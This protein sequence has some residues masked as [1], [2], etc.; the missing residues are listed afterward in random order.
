MLEVHSHF[1]FGR[2]CHGVEELLRAAV[3]R[4]WP[5]LSLC[6]DRG[7]YGMVEL[8]RAARRLREEERPIRPVLG[9]RLP[10][11]GGALVLAEGRDGLAELCRLATLDHLGAGWESGPPSGWAARDIPLMEPPDPESGEEG[12]AEPPAGLDPATET[13]L[14]VLL[15]ACRELRSCHLVLPGAALPHV[16]P[17]GRPLFLPAGDRASVGLD[18]GRGRV[19][20]NRLWAEARRLGLPVVPHGVTDYLDAADAPLHQRIRALHENT[21]RQRILLSG[22]WNLRG[23]LPSYQ[24]FIQPFAAL[25]AA[26]R[27]LEDLWERCPL[28][29]ET[30]KLHLPRPDGD[31]DH[32]ARLAAL[33]RAAL[34]RLYPAPGPWRRRGPGGRPGSVGLSTP[35]DA[36]ARLG[37]ELA[38]IGRLGFA[39]YFL[40]V[41]EITEFV[42]RE[43]LPMIGRGS[44]ANSLVAYC[45]GFTEVDPLR[46][47][48]SFE[49]F[50]N[51]WRSTPPDIDLDFSWADRDRVL[52]FVLERFGADRAALL[53]TTVTLG[54]RGALR[55]LAK[56]EGLGGRELEELTRHFPRGVHDW[57]SE[58]RDHPA[59]YGLRPELEPLRGLLP[60]VR[61]LVGLPR[62]LGIHVGGV[63]VTPGPLTDWLPL[64]RA[65]RGVTVTQLDMHPVE[66]L[67]LL[68]I[69]LLAQRGLGVYADLARGDRAAGR[70]APPV[71][72][73]ELE[74][75]PATAA[76][77]RHGRTMGCF[78]I[79]S[80]GMQA[81][82][83]KLRCDSFE[84]LVAASSIIRP[85]VSESGMMQAYVERHRRVAGLPPGA[86]WPFAFPHPRLRDLLEDTYGVM[87]YQEDVMHVVSGLA[88][89]SLAEGDLLRRAMSGKGTDPVALATLEDRF[90]AGCAAGGVPSA[91]AREVW[92]QIASFAGYAFCKAHSA[93]FAVLSYRL[94]WYKAHQP[95]HFLAAVLSNQGGFFSSAAYVQEARRLG[96]AVAG[97]CLVHGGDRYTGEAGRLRVGWQ[98]IRSLARATRRAILLERAERSFASLADL[99]RRSGA[100]AAELEQLIHAGACDALAGPGDPRE[101]RPALLARLRLE[102][103]VAG[104]R[105]AGSR[106]GQASLFAAIDEA[107]PAT[108]RWSWIELWLREREALGFGISRHPLELF[109][110]G[111]LPARCVTAGELSGQ[112]GRRVSMIGWKFAHKT[113]RT[114]REKQRMAFLSLEDRTGTWEAVLFPECWERHA[115]LTRGQGPFLLEGRVAQEAGEP[116][117]EVEAMRP[118]GRLSELAAREAGAA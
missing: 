10:R 88:G 62:H 104:A 13:P 20:A 37:R 42:R 36:E 64:Q 41:R 26:R 92:R 43:G 84:D 86:A 102:E 49:R 23:G 29:V 83:R 116:M 50:L 24:E 45:L 101:R 73:Y 110:F 51:P 54:P 1:S 21:S 59:R 97:P 17:A 15:E 112:V 87:V 109:D 65:G 38:V 78:Y 56:V 117:L 69:D 9:L 98:Q 48:L 8:E 28:G 55:E 18:P 82:L 34:P 99:R 57:E 71:T 3:G 53:C 61:R 31:G 79:E 85:G 5:A 89:M 67:G 19:A 30:G 118:A 22:R 6:D 46:H 47:R 74:R 4:G 2:G 33:C 70:E 113:I 95:A 77:I 80:P 27:R 105:A 100:S 103:G 11:L 40:V 14:A 114:R 7:L 32:L 58:L 106:A 63:L 39:G 52:R 76:L 25:P 75:D 115:L 60:W 16:C 107:P 93:S 81:L 108:G 94:A 35:A 66:E 68:K 91:T 111:D 90:L 12:A 96:L 72:P 44:A